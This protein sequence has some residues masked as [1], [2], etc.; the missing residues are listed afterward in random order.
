[1][2]HSK[3]YVQFGPLGTLGLNGGGKQQHTSRELLEM[4]EEPNPVA[5][6]SRV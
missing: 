4:M 3:H 6:G 2:T 1:M 5:N